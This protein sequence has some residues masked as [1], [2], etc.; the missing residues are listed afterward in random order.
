MERTPLGTNMPSKKITDQDRMELILARK[1][2]KLI[3]RKLADLYVL[4]WVSKNSARKVAVPRRLVCSALKLRPARFTE[5]VNHLL[6]L[7]ILRQ[8]FNY[9]GKPGQTAHYIVNDFGSTRIPQLL[10]N[11]NELPSLL[12]ELL[13]L[14][15][16]KELPADDPYALDARAIYRQIENERIIKRS[17]SGSRAPRKPRKSDI[18]MKYGHLIPNNPFNK[19]N[20]AQSGSAATASTVVAD[21]AGMQETGTALKAV[22]GTQQLEK[23]GA[24]PVKQVTERAKVKYINNTVSLIKEIEEIELKIETESKLETN[25]IIAI[26]SLSTSSSA[27][28]AVAAVSACSIG[29]DGQLALAPETTVT[30]SKEIAVPAVPVP[31]G[32]AAGQ[33]GTPKADPA[34]LKAPEGLET[35][36][37]S[38][39]API[40]L[41]PPIKPWNA[42]NIWTNQ[43]ESF[44]PLESNVVNGVKY[45]FTSYNRVVKA[46]PALRVRQ[47]PLTLIH[48]TDL[49]TNP[50][51]YHIVEWIGSKDKEW[52]SHWTYCLY[53]IQKNR[54]FREGTPDWKL[55]LDW[56]FRHDLEIPG[57][58]TEGAEDEVEPV[59]LDFNIDRKVLR[60]WDKQDTNGW[61][62]YS[63]GKGDLDKRWQWDKDYVGWYEDGLESDEVLAH[64]GLAELDPW[65]APA[66]NTYNA[67]ANGF[68]KDDGQPDIECYIQ[69]VKAA[70]AAKPE[71][72]FEE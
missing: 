22:K 32:E 48:G 67:H 4:L 39:L 7:G 50:F 69:A 11:W 70:K 72:E 41:A 15:V 55:T 34:S 9:D 30:L 19:G 49:H 52:F 26:F 21:V 63:P 38:L 62:N 57:V 6:R 2:L 40:I 33:Q 14:P 58:D 5:Y 71:K 13:K 53:R 28:T 65:F 47:V 8:D 10:E 1:V 45:I 24:A 51:L 68:W 35:S 61:Y 66:I 18:P 36:Y 31:Q 60:W 56:L 46:V 27:S 16:T 20:E 43:Y 17:Q 3:D 44:N 42:T 37:Q 54:F 59:E 23:K 29:C 64:G 12:P 25:S